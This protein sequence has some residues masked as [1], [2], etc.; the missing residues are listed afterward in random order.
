[1][2]YKEEKTKVEPKEEVKEP[3]EELTTSTVKEDVKEDKD[4]D[5]LV[6]SWKDK[7]YVLEKG[8][9]AEIVVRLINKFSEG[10]RK[11][12]KIVEQDGMLKVIDEKENVIAKAKISKIL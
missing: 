3:V 12:I 2:R 9:N 5:G 6:V 1:M 8:R 7:L 4:M 10:K 11:N